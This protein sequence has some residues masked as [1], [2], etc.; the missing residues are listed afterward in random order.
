MSL[1]NCHVI[2][3]H[4]HYSLKLRF[5]RSNPGPTV[6]CATFDVSMVVQNRSGFRLK[7]YAIV[8]V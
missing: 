2:K 7:D 8:K 6:V 3:C 5:R 1:I 4:Q